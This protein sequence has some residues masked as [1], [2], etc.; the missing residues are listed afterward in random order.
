MHIEELRQICQEAARD[1]L[2]KEGRPLPPAVVLPRPDATQVLL[3]TGLPEKDD[4][5]LEVMAHLADEQLTAR[6][7]PAWGFVSEGEVGEGA[8]V[9]VVV[10]GARRNAPMITA[11]LFV[12]DG[13]AEFEP[14][15][16][17]DPHAFPFLHP[18][19][20]AVDALPAETPPDTGGR[21]LPLA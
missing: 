12:G 4:A 13:L 9:A 14:A 1:L 20:R 10:Y 8:A 17:L 3:L 11:A 18:L 21:G 2:S 15:E 6:G 16:E 7:T 19:Q 5:R